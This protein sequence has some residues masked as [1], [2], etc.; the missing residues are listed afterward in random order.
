MESAPAG[1]Q[2][3]FVGVAYRRA[4]E[5]HPGAVSAVPDLPPALPAVGARRH[6][7]GGALPAGRG[8]ARAR[9]P[10]LERVLHRRL[11]LRGEKG[12]AKVGPTKRGKGTKVMAVADGAGLPLAVGIASA[13]PHEVRLVEATL[14][15]RFVAEA[16]ARLIGDKAYDSDRL[17]EKLRHERAIELIAPHSSNRRVKTQDGRPLRRFRRRWK[18]ERLFAWLH[19]FRRLVVRYEYRAENFL[20]MLH[21]ACIVILLRHL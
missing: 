11:L 3:H 9:R 17:D 1:A 15:A 4:V 18:I 20:G 19:N 8:S 6:P 2:R 16:P 5:R 10:G 14:D 12:G 21:L 13:S 7:R